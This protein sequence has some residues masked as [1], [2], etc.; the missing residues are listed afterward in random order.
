MGYTLIEAKVV[1]RLNSHNDPRD[2]T[3]RAL[4]NEMMDKIER[5]I[6]DPTYARIMGT[7]SS[8][9]PREPVSGYG[10]KGQG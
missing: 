6:H 8:S 4:W 2:D 7:Q 9:L 5:I 3:D 10:W 1:G